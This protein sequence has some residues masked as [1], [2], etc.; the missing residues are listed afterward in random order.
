MATTSVNNYDDIK[1]KRE[2]ENSID[3]T[4][5]EPV[6]HQSD[7][8]ED[9][10][11]IIRSKKKRH[12]EVVNQ[13]L[14]E[15]IPKTSSGETTESMR[16]LQKKVETMKVDNVYINE[17]SNSPSMKVDDEND[18]KEPSEGHP[19]ED[20][21]MNYDEESQDNALE[22]DDNSLVLS[23][24]RTAN[25]L[26]VDTDINK[27]KESITS[28]SRKLSKTNDENKLSIEALLVKEDEEDKK[29]QEEILN[30]SDKTLKNDLP[31]QDTDVTV[32]GSTNKDNKHKIDTDIEQDS[33]KKIK[34][35]SEKPIESI[36][37]DEEKS[38][39]SKEN[40]S[41]ITTPTKSSTTK[42]FGS[43]FTP[44]TKVFGSGITFS[45][46]SSKP[47]GFSSFATSTPQKS[48]FDSIS[49]SPP[50]QGI[51]GSNSKYSSPLGSFA[52][53]PSLG[54]QSAVQASSSTR[55]SI[56]E[57]HDDDDN[58]EDD[59]EN[60]ESEEEE[61]SFGIGAKPLLQEQEVVT[62][63]EDE[64]TRYSVKAKL[65]WMDKTQQWKERGV[66]TLRLNYP[67]DDSKSPRIVMRADGVLKVILNVVLFNG[68][69][70]ERAQEKFVR[71]VAFEGADHIPV[72][73]A[74]KVGNPSAADELYDAIMDAIPQPQRRPQFRVN[75]VASRA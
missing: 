23:K 16:N 35:S 73:L 28:I 42:V 7:S 2:R 56:F 9:N 19:S 55:T 5:K 43:S 38:K 18:Q 49:K 54:F 63:E 30:D 11:K 72:H 58:D 75:T 20:E 27:G 14:N 59:P 8:S 60:D 44:T 40:N 32:K 17:T 48:I 46:P 36:Q 65:Y 64:I 39:K 34:D 51:F 57:K 71:L 29:D 61:S 4:E 1:R 25:A 10:N 47:L 69:S 13:D 53:S 68:M 33:S 66:G 22:D 24:K 62:G 52:M 12:D 26:E 3:T 6:E 50:Q 70:V 67:R 31:D 45:T 74:I 15:E 21:D 41:N 37:L